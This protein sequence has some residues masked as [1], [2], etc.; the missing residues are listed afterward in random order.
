MYMIAHGMKNRLSPAS[1]YIQMMQT[2]DVLSPSSMASFEKMA[3][4]SIMGSI[5]FYDALFVLNDTA[6]G[7][8]RT[9]EVSEWLRE[10][11]D[12]AG[13]RIQ[14]TV[15][16]EHVAIDTILW[17]AV[18]EELFRNVS[19]HGGAEAT[20]SVFTEAERVQL[21]ICDRGP[22]LA[23][24]SSD[25]F[26]NNAREVVRATRRRQDSPGLGLGLTRARWALLQLH[27]DLTLEEAQPHGLVVTVSAATSRPHDS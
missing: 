26:A 18:A 27:G 23:T 15:D 2:G 6:P 24:H 25:T 19:M 9:V 5:D 16:C 11:S 20:V 7:P 14:L 8:V 3:H 21:T 13:V 22:G 12:A 10:I 4:G 17:R 1:T